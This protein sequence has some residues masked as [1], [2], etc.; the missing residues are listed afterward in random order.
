M[1]TIAINSKLAFWHWLAMC[2][3]HLNELLSCAKGVAA[4]TNLQ[5][6]DRYMNM[7]SLWHADATFIDGLVSACT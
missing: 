6:C 3:L 5:E 4:A 7:A 1:I 2:S